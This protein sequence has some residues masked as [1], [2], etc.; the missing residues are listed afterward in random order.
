M[1]C[2]DEPKN[3]CE[4]PKTNENER[5]VKELEEIMEL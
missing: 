4:E 5:E 3:S 1:G 2:V